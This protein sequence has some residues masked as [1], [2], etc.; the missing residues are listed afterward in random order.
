MKLA[1]NLPQREHILAIAERV[2]QKY[3]SPKGQCEFMTRD[4]MVALKNA[5]MRANH[6]MGNFHLDEPALFEYISSDDA[7]DGVDEYAV[8]HDWVEIGGK[9]LDISAKQ[10]QPYIHSP[11]PD[12]LFI[13]VGDPLANHYEQ[14]GYADE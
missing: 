8:N 12:I 10:F 7:E 5:G 4:L 1:Q 2:S 14:L 13:S 11:I 9:I 3:S 6:V